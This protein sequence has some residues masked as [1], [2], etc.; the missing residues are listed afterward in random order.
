MQQLPTTTNNPV[1]DDPFVIEGPAGK[2]MTIPLS[3]K[4][5]ETMHSLPISAK[6]E[7]KKNVHEYIGQ[8]GKEYKALTAMPL[9][10]APYAG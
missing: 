4:E 9:D 3:D 1:P 7:F 6:D 8:M 5:A 10:E 2:W